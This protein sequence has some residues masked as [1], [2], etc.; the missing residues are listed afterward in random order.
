MCDGEDK[1]DPKRHDSV[2]LTPS[3][4]TSIV[5]VSRPSRRSDNKALRTKAMP[6]SSKPRRPLHYS[7]CTGANRSLNGRHSSRTFLYADHQRHSD[8]SR[9]IRGHGDAMGRV[10]QSPRRIGCAA[11]RS[12]FRPPGAALASAEPVPHGRCAPQPQVDSNPTGARPNSFAS[13]AVPRSRR[14][15][16]HTPPAPAARLK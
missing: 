2:V 8:T 13:G 7:S 11:S 9:T 4:P 5:H 6:L 15:E 3:L 10:P 1:R 14:H 16:G 12:R